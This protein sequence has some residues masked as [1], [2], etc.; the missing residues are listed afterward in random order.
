EP[1]LLKKIRWG[2]YD[3]ID[4]FVSIVEDPV[5]KEFFPQLD[6]DA[7][8]TRPPRDFP[9]NFPYLHYLK[10]KSYT[11]SHPLSDEDILSD[12]VLDRVVDAFCLLKPLNQFFNRILEE[13]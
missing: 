8:L 5:F 13:E 4:E 11:V 12:D 2:I 3:N 10:F 1:A 6:E 7:V 9:A